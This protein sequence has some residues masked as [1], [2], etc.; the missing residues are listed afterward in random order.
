ML[1][2]R[3]V[4][5][6]GK[7]A[8]GVT[9]V[10]V[11]PAGRRIY[12]ASLDGSVREWKA[13]GSR[14]LV[15]FAPK[16]DLQPYAL[17]LALASA[18]L[19]CGMQYGT[20]EL[21]SA[22]TGSLVRELPNPQERSSHADDFHTVAVHP[23]DPD[24]IAGSN[25]RYL[26]VWRAGDG[27]LLWRENGFR[28]INCVR[29][30]RNGRYLMAH[31]WDPW[32]HLWDFEKR[33]RVEWQTSIMETSNNWVT[34]AAAP[35]GSKLDFVLAGFDGNNAELIGVNL[36][37]P[38]AVWRATT[39]GR[40]H[41]VSFLP[42]GRRLL[43]CGD[44]GIVELWDLDSWED[45]QQLDLQP[46]SGAEPRQVTTGVMLTRPDLDEEFHQPWTVH[47]LDVAGD[48]SFA[49]FGLAGGEVGTVSL[50]QPA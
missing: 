22:A 8:A 36:D 21:R 31:E 15:R 17:T 3:D 9:A 50:R 6:L 40:V 29:F 38:D 34:A 43:T 23:A 14:E 48:G 1:E 39:E 13:G 19:V 42:D 30:L 25:G 24:V 20:V 10:C 4:E 33:E 18:S 47:T 32:I 16:D 35:L 45:P 46:A 44:T 5:I 27:Q 28:G 11:E 37:S 7:H 41:A 12:S 26:P 49:V 2:F